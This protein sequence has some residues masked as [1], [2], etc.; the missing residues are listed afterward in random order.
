MAPIHD[1]LTDLIGRTPL[2]RL[3]RVTAG[4]PAEIIVKL[5]S[6]NPM[7]SV[8]DRTGWAMIQAAEKVGRLAPGSTIIEPTSGNT[9]VALAFV[10]AARGYKLV[11]AMPDTMSEG[12][13]KLLAAL[14]ARVILTPGALGM[15][16][17]VEE[18]M[19]LAERTPGAF[20]PMQFENP[21]NPD[22]HR[23]TTAEEIWSDTEGRLDAFVAGV[24]TG[25]TITG[26]GEVL[27][28]RLPRVRIVGVEPAESPVLS[29]G[30]G[31]PHDIQGIGAG[32]VP[33]VL[34]RAI[35]DE[36]M[37][38][39]GADAMRMTRR[40]AREE[41]LL[42]GISSGAAV[43]ASMRL[44]ERPE[45]NGRRIV[46]LLASHGERYLGVPGLFEG[47]RHGE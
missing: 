46:T 9:G 27:K 17:A 3:N 19:A 41:G 45:M 2:V 6:M 37:T 11:L 26:V 42:V 47:D 16:G 21:A 35:L 8:K 44:A 1:N 24:G 33:P 32:F 31:A 5:E 12:R 29:G 7:S 15:K 22:V 28:A 36:V 13:V 43:T 34:N 14:G 18:A 4:L 25:G 30:E 10:S 20:V 23:R 39:S 38:V 40:L